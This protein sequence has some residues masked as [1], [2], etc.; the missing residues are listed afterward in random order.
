MRIRCFFQKVVHGYIP[1]NTIVIRQKTN[2]PKISSC[3]TCFEILRAKEI[4]LDRA[5]IEL[6]PFASNCNRRDGGI[7]KFSSQF[8]KRI[9]RQI[10]GAA[11]KWARANCAP[12]NRVPAYWAPG[13]PNWALANWALVNRASGNGPRQIGHTWTKWRIFWEKLQCKFHY[14]WM[15][16]TDY[17][18]DS[19]HCTQHSAPCRYQW[20][21]N[22]CQL[23]LCIGILHILK[24]IG[25]MGF[26][27]IGGDVSA[28]FGY[29][30]GKCLFSWIYVHIF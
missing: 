1:I 7:R 17:R 13:A 23:N 10:F 5:C 18:S 9:W 19:T 22:V 2:L 20:L 12:A 11:E 15:Q 25:G 6:Q 4:R 30:V 26:L 27:S 16:H 3:W 29:G 8:S 28:P 24:T 21:E 14:S